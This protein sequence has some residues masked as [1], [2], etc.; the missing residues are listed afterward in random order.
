MPR[1]PRIS[2][3]GVA[4]HVIQRGNNRPACFV[5]D[6]DHWAYIGWLKEY[7]SRDRVD[8]HAWVMM[9]NHVN[10]SMAVGSNRFKQEIE[11]LTGRRMQAKKEGDRWGGA[12]EGFRKRTEEKEKFSS[13]MPLNNF[14]EQTGCTNPI[15]A[16]DRSFGNLF[17]IR[18]AKETCKSLECP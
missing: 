5:S 14:I 15:L 1:Q 3:A 2:P 6:E 16:I 4:V 7:A 13:A 10:K 9:T 11:A 17:K 18:Q 12:K 8:L